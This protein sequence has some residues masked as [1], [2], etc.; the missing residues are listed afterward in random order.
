[1]NHPGILL[2]TILTLPLLAGGLQA[3]TSGGRDPRTVAH[4]IDS[5]IN[6][7]LADQKVP[8]SPRAD[9]AEFLRRAYLDITGRIPTAEQAAAFLDSTDQDKRARLIDALLARPEYGQNFGNVWRHLLIP[10]DTPVQTIA[11]SPRLGEFLALQ[12]NENPGWDKMVRRLFAR[13]GG[14]TAGPLDQLDVSQI[15]NVVLKTGAGN[16]PAGPTTAYK[17][18]LFLGVKLLCAEC[19]NDRF[20][21]W[22]QDDYWGLVA[23]MAGTAAVKIP[24]NGESKRVGE[25]I[26]A[27]FIDGSKPLASPTKGGVT[28]PVFL[29]WL[30]ANENKY[31]AV[32]GVNRLWLH[33]FNRGLVNPV[34]D[35]HDK[36]PPSHPAVMDLLT[37]EFVASGF[38]LKHVIRCIC[39]SETYQRT[40]RAAP[41]NETDRELFSHMALKPLTAD[42]LFDS[43]GLALGAREVNL[44]PV[45]ARFNQALTEGGP[46]KIG[47]RDRFINFFANC[48][49]QDDDGNDYRRG[50][51]QQLAL[52]NTGGLNGMSLTAR[53]LA[54]LPPGQAVERLFL[55]TYAR[56]PSAAEARL[57]A[58]YLAQR[59]DK[60][61]AEGYASLLWVLLV[62]SEFNVVR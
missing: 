36:N 25:S 28:A 30:T 61:P 19:H 33:F 40:S 18:R 56:R 55:G 62:S 21:Q 3:Q 45:S 57:A 4:A 58:D 27:R 48:K 41:G 2:A 29:D 20:K 26:A 31:F 10:L 49:T 11:A 38:D 52:M 50:V 47:T 14:K 5:A 35:L 54:K 42:Q 1:M 34:G 24:D 13:T 32:N 22:T 37:K 6:Q 46:P 39:N 8:A 51:P 9:D 43:L 53:E 59:P 44:E 17:A 60:D 23:G 7:K 16:A 15:M 12:F